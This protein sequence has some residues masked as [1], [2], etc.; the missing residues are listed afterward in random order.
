M[1]CTLETK[2]IFIDYYKHFYI[3]CT[4][5]NSII[6]NWCRRI[7]ALIL[8]DFNDYSHNTLNNKSGKTIV[9]KK[10]KLNSAFINEF[11]IEFFD[12]MIL[13]EGIDVKNETLIWVHF[14][15][16][17]RLYFDL[18]LCRCKRT[19]CLWWKFMNQW[20]KLLFECQNDWL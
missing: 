6:E 7:K 20:T 17:M 16:S 14:W 2:K 18:F 11:I 12:Q 1:N 9:R 5:N 3:I 19:K 10:Y 4:R 8:I 15:N 13:C